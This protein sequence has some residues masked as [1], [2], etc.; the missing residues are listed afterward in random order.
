MPPVGRGQRNFSFAGDLLQ[1]PPQ[2]CTAYLQGA[3]AMLLFWEGRQADAL[4]FADVAVEAF[5]G[6]GDR[7][8]EMIARLVP[9]KRVGTA[10][11]VAD[12][13]GFLASRE[14]GY[15]TGQIISVNGG[16]A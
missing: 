3:L 7:R 11:E 4:P 8:S 10:D 6:C 5:R 2:Q 13:V 15:I 12:L 14:A 1:R 9:M 16:M